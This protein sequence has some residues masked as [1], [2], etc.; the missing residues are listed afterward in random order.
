MLI[1][2]KY[3][4]GFITFKISKLGIKKIYKEEI[5]KNDIICINNDNFDQYMNFEN[6][7][8]YS[9]HNPIGYPF[10]RRI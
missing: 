10:Y 2:K 6:L 7:K 5:N 8:T 1:I 9:I 3:L 4:L